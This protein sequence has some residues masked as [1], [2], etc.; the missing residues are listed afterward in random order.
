[1]NNMT[2][3]YITMNCL[4]LWHWHS[5]SDSTT[6]IF[7]WQRLSILN[8]WTVSDSRE[9][10]SEQRT[11]RE[12]PGERK[13]IILYYFSNFDFYYHW[14]YIFS[15]TFRN[16][17]VWR[18][19]SRDEQETLDLMTTISTQESLEHVKHCLTI[20]L[21]LARRYNPM[22]LLFPVFAKSSVAVRGEEMVL[23]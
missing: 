11:Q 8:L 9:T 2:W 12:E 21:F 19:L 14:A 3:D 20:E 1:M 22:I 17:P 6:V 10:Q 16:K 15:C 13:N 23:I 18:G 4:S 7:P 5:V